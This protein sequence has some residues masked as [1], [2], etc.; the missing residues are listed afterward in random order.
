M[1]ITAIGSSF[2]HIRPETVGRAAP[3]AETTEPAA[4][5]PPASRPGPTAPPA[6]GRAEGSVADEL[7]AALVKAQEANAAQPSPGEA[8]RAYAGA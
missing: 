8:A 2:S 7:R 6:V 1:S 3:A 5:T 4:A